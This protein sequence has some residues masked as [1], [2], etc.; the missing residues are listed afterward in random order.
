MVCITMASW[1]ILRHWKTAKAPELKDWASAMIEM[2]S[3]ESMLNRV[4]GV[5]E[6]GLSPWEELWTYI[7]VI[8]QD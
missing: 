5:K 1:I 4:N 3:Y 2:A 7:T 6:D 8:T